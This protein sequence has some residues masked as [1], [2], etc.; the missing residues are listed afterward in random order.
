MMAAAV[1]SKAAK[2]MESNKLV[3]ALQQAVEKGIKSP[4]SRISIPSAIFRYFMPIVKVPA[5]YLRAV[6]DY[7]GG[8]FVRGATILRDVNSGRID[9]SPELANEVYRAFARAS[10]GGVGMGITAAALVAGFNYKNW[11]PDSKE[12]P[13]AFGVT[14][15]QKFLHSP[16]L[17]AFRLGVEAY[18]N[19]TQKHDVTGAVTGPAATLASET[20]G[21]YTFD[22]IAQIIDGWHHNKNVGSDKVLDLAAGPLVP[23]ALRDVAGAY[24]QPD[25]LGKVQATFTGE[26]PA[27]R[28][29]KNPV[30]WL[31]S[32]VPGLR[33]TLPKK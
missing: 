1:E 26:R 11:L 13:Q 5:N 16:A 17:A 27:A 24:D 4:D 23:A 21:F 29:I 33:Q 28:V 31:K 15:P 30:D 14:L 8:G 6:S 2:L 18:N 19:Y 20:P 12:N 32:N 25:T 22:H 9:A 10:V 7:A 3:D